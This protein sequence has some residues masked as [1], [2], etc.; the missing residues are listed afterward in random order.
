MK[1]KQ[2]RKPTMM[3]RQAFKNYTENHRNIGKAMIDAGYSEATAKCPSKNL[4]NTDAWKTMMDED[5][6]EEEVSKTI[7]MGMKATKRKYYVNE[8]GKKR[9]VQ[10]PDHATRHKYVETALKLRGRMKDTSASSINITIEKIA[11]E[12]YEQN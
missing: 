10:D 12:Y 2:N 5:F 3:Q 6:P 9:W 1:K 8:D 4:T 7:G 11:K